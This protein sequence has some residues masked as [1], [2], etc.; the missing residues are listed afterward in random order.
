MTLC[1]R[2]L[3]AEHVL[4]TIGFRDHI[5]WGMFPESPGD[6]A[7]ASHSNSKGEALCN[8]YSSE[9]N[10]YE[11]A[12][13]QR[14]LIYLAHPLSGP[15]FDWNVG[16][17]IAW[18]RYFRSLPVTQLNA[19]C[20]TEFSTPPVFS[21]PWLV[22]VAPDESHPRGRR[23][24]LDD[25]KVQVALHSELWALNYV[26]AGMEDERRVARRFRDMTHLGKSPPTLL[27]VV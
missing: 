18:V 1:E 7:H 20:N 24:A 27:G 2:C 11:V 16:N 21:A 26:S 22:G 3:T 17:A 8:R 12:R 5:Q 4:R 13:P 15:N 23:G 25:C 19:I 10:W 6:T 9:L 14:E